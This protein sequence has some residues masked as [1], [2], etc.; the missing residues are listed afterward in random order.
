MESQNNDAA[1]KLKVIRS[2][3]DVLLMHPYNVFSY[4][5]LIYRLL[6]LG[7]KRKIPAKVRGKGRGP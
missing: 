7:I 3:V 2:A 5:Y 4:N 6:K 1:G